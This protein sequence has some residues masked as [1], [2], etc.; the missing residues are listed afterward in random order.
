MADQL[1]ILNPHNKLTLNVCG[2]SY[3]GSELMITSSA[4]APVCYPLGRDSS[5]LF[6]FIGY[7]QK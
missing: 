2:M 4:I 7:F 6:T 1:H 3:G 5:T